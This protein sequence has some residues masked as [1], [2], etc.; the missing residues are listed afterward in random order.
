MFGPPGCGKG[1]QAAFVAKRFR[2]PTISTGDLL[3][4]EMRADTSLGR[5]A[6]LI[7]QQGGLVGDDIVNGMVAARIAQPDCVPGFLLDGYPRTLTQARFLDNLLPDTGLPDPVVIHLDVPTNVLVRRTTM[8]RQCS[9]CH[10]VYNLAHH[11]PTLA[12]VCDTDGAGLICRPDDCPLPW[13]TLSSAE[14]RSLA[15]RSPS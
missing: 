3:R 14:R 6:S 2:I 4:A 9:E 5:Q 1:T 13:T 11:P 12:G 15:R 8:R 10:R 7:L